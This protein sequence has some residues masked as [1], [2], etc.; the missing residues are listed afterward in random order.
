MNFAESGSTWAEGI[1]ESID[2]LLTNVMLVYLNNGVT[3]PYLIVGVFGEDILDVADFRR[4]GKDIW[5][6][7]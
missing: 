5:R 1:S 4:I 7:R 3:H 2:R 6:L